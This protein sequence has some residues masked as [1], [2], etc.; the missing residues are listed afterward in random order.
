[1]QDQDRAAQ[2]AELKANSLY[3][4]VYVPVMVGVSALLGAGVPYFLFG[5]APST[6]LT[7]AAVFWW[8][9]Y[10]LFCVGVGVY[11][12]AAVWLRLA[13]GHVTQAQAQA[14]K[15]LRFV[16]WDRLGWWLLRR[17]IPDSGERDN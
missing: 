12:A 7:G 3:L 13:R 9:A 5:I 8:S 16:S 2:F 11:A 1:M 4:F 6:V 15:I 10:L 14:A 17:Y